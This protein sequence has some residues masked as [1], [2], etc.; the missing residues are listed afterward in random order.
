M[1]KVVRMPKTAVPAGALTSAK[2]AED[3]WAQVAIL[4]GEPIVDRKLAARGTPPGLVARIP[5]GMRAFAI[6]VNEQSGVSGFVLP[7][8]RVDVVQMESGS[9]GHTEAEAVLQDVLVLASGQVFTRP[10]DRSLQSRTVTLAVTPDQVDSLVSAKSRGS[11]TLSLRGLNDHVRPRRTARRPP[12]PRRSCLRTRRS[13]FGTRAAPD[14]G[15]GSGRRQ[16]PRAGPY[17]GA[18]AAPPSVGLRAHHHVARQGQVGDLAAR[19]N[20]PGTSR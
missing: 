13:P 4:E 17:R 14:Q 6:E 8:H 5:T 20:F 1:V 12:A 3:R 11:L 9:N 16:G 7:G 18:A 10:D 2:D 15:A 19:Q